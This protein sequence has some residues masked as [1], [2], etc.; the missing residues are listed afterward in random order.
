VEINLPTLYK[1]DNNGTIRQ[2]RVWVEGNEYFVEHGM[3]GGSL[4]ETSTECYGKNV[5]R[6]NETTDEEQAEFEAKALWTK[7]KE[8]KG[9]SEDKTPKKKFSPMLA[10]RYD[11]HAAKI[12]FPA[13]IQQKLDGLRLIVCNDRCISR[14]GKE[15]AT[16]DHIKR[17][18]RKLGLPKDTVLDGELYSHDYHDDFQTFIGL[19]KRDEPLKET[20]SIQYHIY[21]VVQNKSYK[22]RYNWLLD[23]VKECETIKLVRS[24]LINDPSEVSQWHSKFV[25]E[26]YEGA[27]LRNLNGVYEIG[28]RS[29][30][31][32]KVKQFD[33]DEFEIVGAEENKGK[34][35][36]TCILLCKT[37]EG[38]I[39]GV[40][41]KGTED[42]RRQ[43]WRDY[44][45]GKLINRLLT[46]KYF[47]LSND[48]IP[49]FPVGINL[50]GNF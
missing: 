29:Y 23:N 35:I 28:K 17:A 33:D 6:A 7:Q 34:L 22:D 41:P 38:K 37:K 45:A 13:Y 40:M 44:Q 31:L 19:V 47:G 25:S 4:Q 1:L 27:M 39:F 42:Q 20:K 36:G 48:N 14:T 11:K 12:K 50:R 49:R 3:V 26:G 2:W 30:N 9:Y 15:F 46:V 10:Q 21:D 43:Y 32:Q 8:R 24:N 18:V 16:L 5:G